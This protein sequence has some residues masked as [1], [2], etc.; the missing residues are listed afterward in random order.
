MKARALAVYRL[1]FKG[2][3]TGGSVLWGSLAIGT[4]V[5]TALVVAAVGQAA[6]LV[7]A[8]CCHLVRRVEGVRHS[9]AEALEE[10]LLDRS[11]NIPLRNVVDVGRNSVCCQRS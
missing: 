8:L 3:M 4:S 1:V 11:L 5:A 9:A 2:A 10:R 6:A 7:L